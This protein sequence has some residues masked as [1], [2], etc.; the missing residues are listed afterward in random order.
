LLP[1][2]LRKREC[3][4]L[5]DVIAA[6]L[7]HAWEI[8]GLLNSWPIGSIP[9]SLRLSLEL[10]RMTA[11]RL[12]DLAREIST[13]SGTAGMMRHIYA[14][15][16]RMTTNDVVRLALVQTVVTSRRVSRA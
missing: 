16:S 3:R 14:L 13:R 8:G 7:L 2:H 9:A 4:I 5:F 12:D 1:S 6:L 11:D 10:D 15:L